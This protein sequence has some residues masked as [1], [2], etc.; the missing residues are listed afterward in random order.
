MSRDFI[1]S[2]AAALQAAG[3]GTRTVLLPARFSLAA[4]PGQSA[5]NSYSLDDVTVYLFYTLCFVNFRLLFLY[6]FD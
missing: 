3:R 4:T 2:R 5:Y 6:T 1:I